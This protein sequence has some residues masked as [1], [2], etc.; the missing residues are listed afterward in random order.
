MF[1]SS[2]PPPALEFQLFFPPFLRGTA[3][4]SALLRR[5]I[6]QQPELSATPTFSELATDLPPDLPRRPFP[7]TTSPNGRRKRR[8][9]LEAISHSINHNKSRLAVLSV[10]FPSMS[11]TPGGLM[12]DLRLLRAKRATPADTNAPSYFY[13]MTSPTPTFCLF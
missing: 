2:S 13:D 4:I 12:Q 8:K 6:V 10:I 11:G 9:M 7:P 3:Q 1:S 5:Y